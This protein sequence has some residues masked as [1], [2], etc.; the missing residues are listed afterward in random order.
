MKK[1]LYA[2]SLLAMTLFF[3]SVSYAMTGIF[4][5]P[6]LRDN[7]V[8]DAQW[9]MLMQSV[10]QQGF[11]TLIVQ[12]TQYGDGLAGAQEQAVLLKRMNAARSAGLNLV[13]GLNSD[14]EFFSRQKQSASAL[15]EYLNQLKAAD[16]NQA[17][18]WSKLLPGQFSGWYISAEID[19]AN[20]REP[21]AQAIM[22]KWLGD[23][24]VALTQVANKPVY[25]S[26]FFSGNT[27][28]ENYGLLI[29]ALRN[30][31]LNV[32]IQNGGGTNTLTAA[33]RALYLDESVG[34]NTDHLANGIIYELF[35]IHASNTF[36]ADPKATSDAKE[37]LKTPPRCGKDRL[38]FSLRYL[39]IADGIMQRN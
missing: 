20:W 9:N 27:T 32:W 6:Q 24:R 4:W 34:C 33:Q 38:F 22:E 18:H 7:S 3:S 28:P 1:L 25:I 10:R 26:S 8:S 14:P 13:I 23:T 17:Q 37:I 30:T 29:T 11:D 31:G 15:P 5:Q 19:D 12:W 35:S 16:I 21:A 36:K 2:I 39:P